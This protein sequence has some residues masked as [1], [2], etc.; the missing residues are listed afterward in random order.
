[1][2][3]TGSVSVV[4]GAPANASVT[5]NQTPVTVPSGVSDLKFVVSST[6]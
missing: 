3:V 5:I 1:V 4:L 2:P 6:G